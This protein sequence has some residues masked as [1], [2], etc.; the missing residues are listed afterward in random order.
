MA[1][2]SE[3]TREPEAWPAR[4]PR[5]ARHTKGVA[6]VAAR[7][8]QSSPSRFVLAHTRAAQGAQTADFPEKLHP[9]LQKALIA[10]GQPRLYA[11]QRQAFDLAQ[12]GQ[13]VVIATPTASGKSLA[14]HLPVLQHL[15]HTPDAR[16]LYLYPTKALSRDQEDSL[17]K[18]LRAADMD[19]GLITYDGDT[20]GDV[21]RQAK[22][23][24]SIIMTNPDMLHSGILPHH[25]AWARFFAGLTHVVLDELHTLRGVY[26]S[27]MANVLRRLRRIAAFYGA[28]PQFLFASATIG[29]AQ[30]HAERLLGE[31]VAC[32]DNSGAPKGKQHVFVCNPPIVHAGLGVRQGVVKTTVR[33]V[34]ELL[35]ANVSTLVFGQSRASVEVM[36]KYLRDF[37]AEDPQLSPEAIHSYRGGY[38]PNERRAI[39]AAL[40]AG[41]IRCI[42]ATQA[43]E[44]GIDIGTLEAV[45][46][47]SYPGSISGLWQRFG[48]GG[49]RGDESLAVLVAS[50]SPID[51]YFAASP[52]QLLDAPIEHARIDADNVEIL[53]QHIKC[54]AFELPFRQGDTFGSVDAESVTDGLQYLCEHRVLHAVPEEEGLSYHW[55][56]GSYPA[57]EVSLRNISW[58]NFVIIDVARDKTIAEMDWRSAHTML[59]EQAIYQHAAEQWQV[60]KLDFDNRKAFVRKVA[61]DYYTDAITH[62]KV[63]PIDLAQ[64]SA[65]PWANSRGLSA[66]FGEISVV[67]KVVGFKKI[68][69]HTHDNVGQG[70]V[71]LPEM[72]MHTTAFWWTLSA[73]RLEELV[74]EHHVPRPEWVD[75]LRGIGHAVHL[76]ASVGLM[77]DVRDLGHTVEDGNDGQTAAAA[78]EQKP[79]SP[80]LFVFDRMPGGVG[81]AERVFEQ[82][83]RLAQQTRRVLSECACDSGC[84]ACVGPIDAHGTA[85]RKQLAIVLLESL[86]IS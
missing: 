13:H 72:Q 64:T 8:H 18:L 7:W 3:E 32:V 37:A 73:V 58:D 40:R 9:Q 45:V 11:H 19:Q 29:N 21:R 4:A 54:A 20:P 34:S 74:A 66:S 2:F 46:C 6:A 27:H 25:T 63:T 52:Q 86:G 10:R 23:H 15:L 43:L 56:A 12:Q 14:Y 60:E 78:A 41:Q 77:V 42:V 69:Y 30:A 67:E 76:V 82:G 50:S 22:E 70:D 17:T 59:H 31:P 81:L 49:R 39:E 48:R 38:L 5:V 35:R 1:D 26:G 85:K 84:P 53:L 83:E 33:L 55:A 71:N 16:A 28:S 24:G 75:A 36:L 79:F 62:L 68:R 51:Q 61:P 44:L 80:S 57:N 47:A 65:Q